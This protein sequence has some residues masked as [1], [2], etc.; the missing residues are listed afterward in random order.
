MGWTGGRWI[1]LSLEGFRV[2]SGWGSGAFGAAG[3][4]FRSGLLERPK[5]SFMKKPKIGKRT[6]GFTLVE[7]LVTIAIIAALAGLVFSLTRGARAKSQLAASVNRVRD[8]GVRV[9]NYT[10][11]NSGQ[12]PVWKDQSQD[13]YWWG[14]LVEDPKNES[15]LEIFRSP[16]HREFDSNPSSPNLSYG[17]NARVVGRYETS[18]GDDGPK[19]MVNFREPSNVMVLADGAR[20]GGNALLGDSIMPDPER[21]AGKAAALMLDGSARGMT[22]ESDLRPESVWFKTEEERQAS[23]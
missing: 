4:R 17:W 21:Y 2:E 13:L 15:Q 20:K 16:G 8:I 14:M 18:E 12:L 19:R 10:Q 1:I 22:I 7:L 5:K 23:E 3:A 9:Q 11:D 6:G